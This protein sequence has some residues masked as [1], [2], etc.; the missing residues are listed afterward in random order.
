[1][2]GQVPTKKKDRATLAKAMPLGKKP[3]EELIDD[4]EDLNEDQLREYLI[5]LQ[6][7]K[8][9]VAKVITFADAEIE[10]QKSLYLFSQ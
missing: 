10:C 2:G 6:F 4:V 5:E 3:P 9:E 8:S 1:L 7:E